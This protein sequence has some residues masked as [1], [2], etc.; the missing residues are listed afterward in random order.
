M[1]SDRQGSAMPT[2][3]KIIVEVKEGR[4]FAVAD[5]TGSSD[6]YVI[7]TLG[8]KK[9]KTKVKKKTLNPQW[10][11]AIIF[12]IDPNTLEDE[13]VIQVFDY[14]RFSS[15]DK[16]GSLKIPITAEIKSGR[17][18]SQWYTL[19]DTTS[20]A[21]NISIQMQ[22]R[23]GIGGMSSLNLIDRSTSKEDLMDSPRRRPSVDE[24]SPHMSPH[25]SPQASSGNLNISGSNSASGSSFD[26]PKSRHVVDLPS[27]PRSE[28]GEFVNLKYPEA[29]VKLK[30]LFNLSSQ[31]EVIEYYPC[32]FRSR[33]G[34]MF[35]TNQHI[36]FYARKRK[37]EI[38]EAI[39]FNDVVDLVKQNTALLLPTGIEV[40][41]ADAKYLFHGFSN[42]DHVYKILKSSKSTDDKKIHVAKRS[43]AETPLFKAVMNNN[44]DEVKALLQSPTAKE[45]INWQDKF[46]FTVLHS[47]VSNPNVAIIKLLLG[48]EHTNLNLINNDGNTPLHYFCQKFKSP[49]DCQEIMDIFLNSKT[50]DIN[51]RNRI[52]E[53]PLHK[54]VFNNAIRLLL[55]ESLLAHK[56]NVNILTASGETP[57]HYAVRLGRKDLVHVLVMYGADITIKGNKDNKTPYELALQWGYEDIAG[58]IKKVQDLKDWLAKID[59]SDY[60]P[61]FV[62]EELFL[63]ECESLNEQLLERLGIKTSG[64]QL[65]ILN[66]V[67]QLVSQ[68]A[69]AKSPA[70][71]IPI[72]KVTETAPIDPK[73]KQLQALRDR[74]STINLQKQ[75]SEMDYV[76]LGSASWINSSDL[77]FTKAQCSECQSNEIYRSAGKRRE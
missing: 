9:K 44:V 31:E 61:V 6:P 18:V 50:V 67:K 57:L 22:T 10:N 62:K 56:A 23:L 75:L 49:D 37:E 34:H 12:D 42:R 35:I 47:A 52:G 20:G 4:D 25:V 63:E 76:N 17:T 54:A 72:V 46:G 59:M 1:K 74:T 27:V 15:D 32:S 5:R 53:A 3:G 16:L 13:I 21:I 19:S 65:R 7:V 40:H 29:T 60:F 39:A 41:T 58:H 73:Q 70:K 51:A 33:A 14:D 43:E 71:D 26:S 77:E 11:E 69:K 55:V 68:K 66:A 45:E 38:K 2:K 24:G 28:S 48:F 8:G 30:A 64:Q 36:Y